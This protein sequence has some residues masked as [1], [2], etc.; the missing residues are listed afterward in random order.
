MIKKLWILLGII[1]VSQITNA[2][3]KSNNK[4]CGS[5][6]STTK[7]VVII[8]TVGVAVVATAVVVGPLVLPASTIAAIKAGAAAAAAKATAAGASIKSAAI[9]AAPTVEAAT[10]IIAKVKTSFL[11]VGLIK[12]QV[13]PNPEQKLA[14]LLKQEIA[15]KPFEEQLREASNNK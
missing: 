3:T 10:P 4:A 1:V 14:Q 9:A 8:S 7:K 11:V 15:E 2:S 13:A 12:E 6:M 5:G